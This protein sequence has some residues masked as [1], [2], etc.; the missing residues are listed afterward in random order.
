[1]QSILDKEA[2]SFHCN[3]CNGLVV[4]DL[5]DQ[6][7]SV[8][9]GGAYQSI[10]S[11]GQLNSGHRVYMVYRKSDNGWT[12]LNRPGSF[13]EDGKE[14]TIEEVE[15]LMIANLFVMLLAGYETS[16]FALAFCLWHLALNPDIQARLRE[17]ILDAY[18][19]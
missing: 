5:A 11:V 14:R 12:G 15:F 16:G 10:I 17:E 13:D 8:D 4:V 2:N 7:N 9:G 19:G 3:L 1:M 18:Q 6:L